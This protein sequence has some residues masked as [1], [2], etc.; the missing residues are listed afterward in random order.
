MVGSF[1]LAFLIFLDE[2]KKL[3]ATLFWGCLFSLC[4]YMIFSEGIYHGLLS[5]FSWKFGSVPLLVDVILDY[6]SRLVLMPVA[7][8]VFYKKLSVH[9]SLS[10]FLLSAFGGIGY[11]GMVVGKTQFMAS[12]VDFAA[13]VLWWK[14]LGY[15]LRFVR[16]TQTFRRYGF[17]GVFTSF[18][19]L[20]NL[21][22][23]VCVRMI[24]VTPEFLNY[25]VF[26]SLLFWFTLG[27]ASR[28]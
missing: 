6:M 17:L 4:P 9:W 7:I 16:D 22:M 20:V 28:S 13:I 5:L 19:L 21:A 18:S 2:R 10:L 24:Q 27:T 12:V 1:F 23:Y 11:L 25:L 8:Y 3:K 15:E 26:V 14:I